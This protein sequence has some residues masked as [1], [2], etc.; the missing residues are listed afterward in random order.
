MLDVIV[1]GGVLETT[2]VV[3]QIL[4]RLCVD[5]SVRRPWCAVVGET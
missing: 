3:R 4:K 5:P 2:R 1:I